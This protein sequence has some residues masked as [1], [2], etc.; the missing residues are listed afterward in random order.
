MNKL[1]KEILSILTTIDPLDL[2]DID[3][4]EDEYLPEAEALAEMYLSN[5]NHC[6]VQQIKI[7]FDKFFYP[8]AVS[9]A[10]IKTIFNQLS[11]IDLDS[12]D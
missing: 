5:D 7:L 2:M 4:P 11:K 3:L 9:P 10:K 1:E 8:D 6:S 12:L